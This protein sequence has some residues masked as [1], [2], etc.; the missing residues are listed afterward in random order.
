MLNLNK[1]LY[2][3][4]TREYIKGSTMTSYRKYGPYEDLPSPDGK[5][6]YDSL[7]LIDIN[8]GR[9]IK[10]QS[11]K[12]VYSNKYYLNI[13]LLNRSDTANVYN[14]YK[15][16][17]ITRYV[18]IH[19]CN[20]FNDIHKRGVIELQINTESM[21]NTV[22]FSIETFTYD[23][24][25]RF[26]IDSIRDTCSKYYGSYTNPCNEIHI[27]NGYISGSTFVV[28]EAEFEKG[29]DDY[30]KKTINKLKKEATDFC[31]NILK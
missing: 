11:Y 21:K 7:Y 25:I 24:L 19:V 4:A 29:P 28:K 15:N 20:D 27:A 31:K 1:N 2:S 10:F 9:K 13:D 16:Y 22:V 8:S 3:S 18:V 14:F 6:Y 23:K 26:V 30:I 12:D 17:G 5:F